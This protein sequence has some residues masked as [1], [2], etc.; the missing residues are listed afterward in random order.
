MK[1]LGRSWARKRNLAYKQAVEKATGANGR[2]DMNVLSA[3]SPRGASNLDWCEFLSIHREARRREIVAKNKA[4]KVKQVRKN[5]GEPK[6]YNTMQAQ[7]TAELGYTSS[8]GFIWLYA[9]KLEDGT[10]SP[11]CTELAQMIQ[12]YENQPDVSKHHGPDDSLH[13]AHTALDT[14]YGGEH[15]RRLRGKSFGYYPRVFDAASGSSGQSIAATQH[16]VDASTIAHVR[17]E[18]D[19][20]YAKRMQA[21]LDRKVMEAEDKLEKKME[22]KF[23]KLMEK[24]KGKKKGYSSTEKRRKQQ[25]AGG[26]SAGRIP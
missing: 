19:Q 24:L 21:E 23:K 25:L 11:D 16:N 18:M 13:L 12:H 6:P 17:E 1:Q 14:T 20:A 3:S 10:F 8:R 15:S 5:R 7:L 26:S 2:V 22:G 9:Q 4:N